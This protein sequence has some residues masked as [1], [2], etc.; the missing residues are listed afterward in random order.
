MEILNVI[1]LQRTLKKNHIK[2]FFF[3]FCVLFITFSYSTQTLYL[4]LH[5]YQLAK[6]SVFHKFSFEI[7][8][9]SN[10]IY[11]FDDLFRH[12]YMSTIYHMKVFINR[13]HLTVLIFFTPRTRRVFQIISILK[14][15]HF[16]F[17]AKSDT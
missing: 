16:L 2:N 3:S 4:F 12:I 8:S 6:L 5:R 15:F 11:T 17:K 13:S 1:N 10:L 14:N 9:S 7:Y